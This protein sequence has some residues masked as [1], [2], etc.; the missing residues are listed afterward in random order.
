ML[1]YFSKRI[2]VVLVCLLVVPAPLIVAAEGNTVPV[3][4]T[5]DR[6]NQSKIKSDVKG[7]WAEKD[8]TEWYEKQLI[9]GYRDGNFKPDQAISRVEFMTLMNRVFRFVDE[10]EIVFSD[11]S[12]SSSFYSEMKKA[13]A[14]GYIS[15]YSDGTI[16][17]GDSISRQE[18]AVILVRVFRLSSVAKNE[19][20]LT[21][22]GSLPSWSKEAVNALVMEG[23]ATGYKDQTFKPNNK[24]TRAEA[25]RLINN[26]SGEILNQAGTYADVTSKNIIINTAN[27]TLKNTTIEG[28]LYLTEG[29][30]EGDVILDNVK[31]K[32]VVKVFGGGQ[33]SIKIKDSD[34]S[35]V[36][37]DKKNGKLRM[38]TQ[39][40]TTVG[41]V[42]T[43]SG[44][45]LEEAADLT[46]DGFKNVLIEKDTAADATIELDGNFD[47]VEISAVS[48][49]AIK[50]LKGIISKMI[51][52]Q[53]AALHVNEAAE[54][55]EIIILFDGKLKVTGK[56]KV[57]SN[58]ENEAKLEREAATISAAGGNG[59]GNET[60]VPTTTPAPTTTPTS[61]PTPT[62][63][64][65][66]VSVHDPS[67]IKVDETYYVFGSHLAAA[68]SNDLMSWSLIDSGV[69]ET[70]KL[71][72]SAESNVK[73][74]LAEALGWAETDTL[75]AADVIQLADGKFYMYYNACKGD[76][77][78][79]ALGV[80]VAD[81]IEGPYVNKGIFLKSGKGISAEGTSYDG[82]KHPNVV[83]P[84]T[85]FDKDGRL[86]MVYGSYS[87]GIFILEMNAETGFPLE[88]QGYGKRLMGQNHSRIEAPYIQYHPI[89]GYYYLFVTFGG[90]DSVGGYNMRI[91]RSLK[92]DG[93]YVDYEGQDMIQAHGPEGSF[94]KDAAIEPYGV[95]SFGNFIFSNINGQENFPTYGYVSAG[96]NSTYYD[97]SN[98]KL[99]NIFHS[100]FPYRGEGHEVRV[101]QMFMNEDG[102]PVV[103]PHRYTGETIGKISESDVVGAY[104]YINH[105]KEITKEIKPSVYIKLEQGGKIT[106]AVTGTWELDGDYYANLKVDELVN[107][108]P[109][110]TTYKGIFIR[111]WDPTSNAYVMAFSALSGKGAAVWGSQLAALTDQELAA[112]AVNRLTLG[113]TSRVFNDV[114]LPVKAAN[115]WPITWESSNV[116]VV[117]ASGAVTRPSAGS[118]DAAVQLTATITLGSATAS[119]T[120]KLIVQQHNESPL[121]DGLVAQYNFENNLEEMTGITAAATVTGDRIDRTGGEI[122]FVDGTTGKGKAASFDGAS[123][124]LLP[125]GLIST[126]E[127]TVS[128]WLNPSEAANIAPAFFGAQTPQSW[129]SFMPR[130][131]DF[132]KNNTMLWSGEA[133][134]DASTGIQIKLNEWTHIA[135]TVKN[136]E[137]QI[138]I[139]G[140]KKYSGTGMPNVFTDKHGLFAL[141]VNYWDTPYKGL[142]DE[143]RIY[144][145]ALNTEKIGWLA[146]GEPDA[147]V[148]VEQIQLGAA[149]KSLAIGTTY[150]PEVI[151]LPVNAANK[152]ITWSSTDSSI[153]IVNAATGQVTAVALGT[154]T[155][156]AT[157]DD[158]GHK[159]ATYIVHVTDGEN[160]YYAFDSNLMDSL[161]RVSAGTITGNRVDNTGGSITFGTGILGSAAVLDGASGIRLPDGIIEGN[162]YSVSMWLNPAEA[163]N[164]ATAFFGSRTN[165]SWIS[166]VPRGPVNSD[167]MLWSGTAW[168]DAS[169]GLKIN[170]GEW[171][172]IAFTVNNGIAKV[173][174]NGMEKFTGSGFP[175]VF[176]NNSGVFGVGV[177]YW[178]TPFKGA[179][180]ELK[181]YSKALTAEQIAAEFALGSR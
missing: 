111:Q 42:F 118:G 135:F 125:E 85:F 148:L 77:P 151:V 78:L 20:A 16:R 171:T 172:H 157:A 48:L 84:D 94:F 59:G 116:S 87:G 114:S 54:I 179:V 13:I 134:Y 136:G 57:T 86:W 28:D 144:D 163:T 146:F 106:G 27:I 2:A 162:V 158:A 46:G 43:I 108:V 64:F 15:G 29:I 112:N 21:D 60:P 31:V 152:S 170:I 99:F 127:Y 58:S 159:T 72:K 80:A 5:L 26:I 71:F 49:P 155:I 41:Q 14:A 32:G 24:I 165:E 156:I 128:M 18:A 98:G 65:E 131:H 11:V 81:N 176:T 17:P 167:T 23:Y 56:G 115:Y 97:E 55:K 90:L 6:A 100:R 120:F 132:A 34:I 149:E 61:T 69:T 63:T 70:N 139:N 88:N 19:S 73:K 89:S 126:N 181:I 45:K 175:N 145:V 104:H 95:K 66:N 35:Q 160:A 25:L 164:F 107:D 36:F 92:P 52:E 62:P 68:K 177:N 122:S 7:H 37:V 12:A 168:Y 8:F 47:M 3:Q 76:Q 44:V 147:S 123:G 161:G 103:A 129:I 174:I 9:Q 110:Q 142:I 137:T 109:V 22:L 141:G 10:E 121:A 39:G 166:F 150:L 178:D 117:T 4:S 138:F 133:W 30:A 75:W 105:G 74:E 119:K 1:K 143:V 102:W 67:V 140:I 93:P 173:Y 82:T 33:N 79:S 101:H 96:H 51:V 153:A 50:L 130:G 180:D 113:D 169:T 91:S 83:D 124:V 53:K 154:T 40:T 38:V